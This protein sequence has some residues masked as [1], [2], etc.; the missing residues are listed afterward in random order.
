[1]LTGHSGG[2]SFTF[3][4]M[5]ALERIPDWV[6]RIA[7]LDSN[8]A[9]EA[10]KGHGDKFAAWLK[11]S[12]LHVLAV[13]AYHDSIALLNGKTF[14]SENG[15]TWGRSHAMQRDLAAMFP[16]EERHGD[17]FERYRALG[18]RVVFLLKENPEKL[19]LHTRLVEWNG[20]IHVMLLGTDAEEQGYRFFGPRD[21]ED[22]IAGE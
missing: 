13:F 3:G 19:V 12:D 18:G 22:W 14:V 17:G 4:Y 21:Y 6:E 5:N 9:Y 20:F 8:Y 7:F 15:G 10:A 16:F 2:G 1:V 11:A